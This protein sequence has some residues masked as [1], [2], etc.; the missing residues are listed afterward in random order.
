MRKLTI[1][2]I[3]ALSIIN[4]A[5]AEK[6]PNIILILAD[7]IG[8][9]SVGCYGGLSYKTPRIDNLAGHNFATAT[10][11]QYMCYSQLPAYNDQLFLI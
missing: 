6:R 8:T 4:M 1:L 2:T 11:R 10:S 5:L 3:L 7:D 9:E